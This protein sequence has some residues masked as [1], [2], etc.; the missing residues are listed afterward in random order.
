MN[1]SSTSLRIGWAQR[2][3]TPDKPV[4]LQGQFHMR[5]S[6]GV[7]D[8]ITVTVL[9]MSA[10]K[11]P[12]ETA[13][14]VGAD[15]PFIPFPANER[16]R[17]AVRRQIPELDPGRVI[18]HATH[19]HTAP[20][21]EDGFYP[22]VPP[23]VMTGEEYAE[24]FAGRVVDALG[25][26]WRAR[27]PAKAAWGLG[28][29]VVGRNRRVVYFDDLSR[30]PGFKHHPAH[31]TTRNAAMYGNTNDPMFSHVEGYE[32]H[33]VN[34]LYTWNEL[35]ELTG[36]V[37]NL[38]CPSQETEGL[39]QVSADFWHDTRAAIR[40]RLGDKVFILPQCAAAGDQSPHVLWYKEAEKRMLELRGL[41]SRHEIARRIALAVEDVLPLVKKEAGGRLP[42]GHESKIV[43]LPRRMITA[44]E[45]DLIRSDLAQLEAQ[46]PSN[47]PDPAKRLA[48]DS[49]R[50]VSIKR[51]Q[52]GL[53]RYA[54]QKAHSTLAVEVHAIRLGSMA[55]AT[56]PFELFLD[57]GLR[58]KARSPALQTFVVQLAMSGA[59]WAGGYLPTARAEEGESYSANVYCNSVGSAG[60]QVLVEETLAMLKALWQA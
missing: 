23:G 28:Q 45:A 25:E 39:Y 38:A 22:A 7:K 27:R 20:M 10:G 35:D 43:A 24:F 6:Q 37:V 31:C 26:A 47:N 41:D 9:A 1:A 5:I 4:N 11:S 49:V 12:D 32:D 19:T 56:N 3:V 13:V 52:I 33:G 15:A 59:G 57:Y 36:V 44:A 34:L 58:I 51:C 55:W 40:Q 60:G 46:A 18:V 54:E 48:A 8:H 17:E 16:I 14:F 50:A 30:R 42:F 2:D 29:A 53:R 21:M